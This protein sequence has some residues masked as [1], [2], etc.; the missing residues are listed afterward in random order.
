MFFT[1]ILYATHYEYLKNEV[2]AESIIKKENISDKFDIN[3]NEAQI[4]IEP[5]DK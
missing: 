1:V 5:I 2:L 4:K 3:D